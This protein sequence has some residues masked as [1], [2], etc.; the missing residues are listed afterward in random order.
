MIA[1]LGA[2][3][4][5]RPV[6]TCDEWADCGSGGACEPAANAD[7]PR[8]CSFADEE[9]MSGRRFSEF[10]PGSLAGACVEIHENA[11]RGELCEP[12]PNACSSL[13]ECIGGRCL[14]LDQVSATAGLVVAHCANSDSNLS[15][16]LLWGESTT[17]PQ[18]APTA[19]MLNS[20]GPPGGCPDMCG[21][22]CVEIGQACPAVCTGAN[23]MLS[24]S[25]GTNHFCIDNG[26]TYCYG[27][28]KKFQTSYAI[29]QDV[30]LWWVP[31]HYDLLAAGDA[32]TCGRVPGGINVEC[33]GDNTYGQLGQPAGPAQATA[34][35]VD[36]FSTGTEPIRNIAFLSSS[37]T[38]SCAAT[39]SRVACWGQTPTQPGIVTALSGGTIS[40][41]ETG[42]AHACAIRDGHAMCWG[43]NESGQSAPGDP[44]TLVQPTVVLPELRFTN[45]VAGRAHTCARTETNEVYC[46]G[47]SSF[48][49]LGDGAVGP[50]PVR[51]PGIPALGPMTAGTNF[52]CSMYADDHLRCWGEVFQI[53]VNNVLHRYDDN[54][55]CD[56]P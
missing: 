40:A 9:C 8:A 18:F 34:V 51:V 33:W 38:F 2:C 11:K 7:E 43:A 32:H 16:T 27:D 44:S 14:S 31:K 26:E 1:L 3:S 13:R 54:E 52:T 10:A 28:N 12:G 5:E 36:P 25:A 41:L 35:L 15:F 17:F 50:G 23:W 24:V 46:W 55:F 6:H 56:R 4:L 49:Q 37:A 53:V 20:C 19:V 21:T 42:V 39:T 30:A 45:I 47:D 48:D 22:G 29:A